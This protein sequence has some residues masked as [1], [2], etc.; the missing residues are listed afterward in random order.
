MKKFTIKK[1]GQ[2]YRVFLG[3]KKIG[4]FLLLSQAEAYKEF[5]EGVL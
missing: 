3:R 4:S 1:D 2:Y 5:R